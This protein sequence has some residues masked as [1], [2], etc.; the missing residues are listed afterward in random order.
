MQPTS[1]A[2]LRDLVT[3]VIDVSAPQPF[4]AYAFASGDPGADIARHVERA[5]FLEAFGNTP[6]LLAAEYGPYEATS[7][8]LCVIDQRRRLPAGAMRLIIPTPGGPGLKSLNDFE[9]MWNDPA[10]PHPPAMN[11]RHSPFTTW[12]IATLAVVEGYRAPGAAGL[13]SLGL[14]QS[15]VRTALT[16]GAKRFVA[17]LDY[18]VYRMSRMQFGRP[19]V[20]L[21]A[22]RPYLGSEQSLPVSCDLRDWKRR[23]SAASSPVGEIIFNGRGIEAAVRPVSQ[24]R[25]MAVVGALVA[26]RGGAA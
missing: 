7:V 13:V 21:A 8:F 10:T 25:R 23:L 18:T 15:T 19:F 4:G 2:D 24:E 26:R 3:H 14:Y 5:V 17:I 1:D 20:P 6:E 22:P 11:T 12:D 9:A 16:N